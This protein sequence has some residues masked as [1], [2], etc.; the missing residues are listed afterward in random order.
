MSETSKQIMAQKHDREKVAIGIRLSQNRRHSCF[1]EAAEKIDF[2][3][4]APKDVEK[5]GKRSTSVPRER[6]AIPIEDRLLAMGELY[7]EK[8]RQEIAESNIRSAISMPK[9]IA[10]HENSQGCVWNRLFQ[11][12]ILMNKGQRI[13]CQPESPQSY[14]EKLDDV[15]NCTFRYSITT[16]H[17]CFSRVH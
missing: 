13:S 2:T 10:A 16:F 5:S 9:V 17:H 12:K 6:S 14:F 7:E 4:T 1:Y 15:E 8:K 11:E 3:H